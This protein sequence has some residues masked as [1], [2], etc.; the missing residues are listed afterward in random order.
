M[1]LMLVDVKTELKRISC[2]LIDRQRSAAAAQWLE[3]LH[4]QWK[5]RGLTSVCSR[6][7]IGLIS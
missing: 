7:V 2:D 3:Y 5:D 1:Y 4:G 6:Y